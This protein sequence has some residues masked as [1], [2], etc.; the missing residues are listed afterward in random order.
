MEDKTSCVGS[1]DQNATTSQRIQEHVPMFKMLFCEMLLFSE[2][3]C[4]L[5]VSNEKNNKNIKDK[6]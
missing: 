5:K 6:N 1:E 2:I 3:L 4:F